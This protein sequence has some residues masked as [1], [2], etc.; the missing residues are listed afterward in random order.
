MLLVALAYRRGAAWLLGVT[1]GLGYAGVAVAAR[2]AQADNSLP[3]LVRRP[4]TLAVAAC[5]VVAVLAYVRAL[6]RGSVGSA[7]AWVAV[8]EVVV[9]A[10]VGVALLGDR[11]LPSRTPWAVTGSVLALAA[12]VVLARSPSQLAT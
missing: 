10:V 7:A 4:E 3:A 9:P 8:V 5:G 6:E 2:G 11:V 1:S 12:C